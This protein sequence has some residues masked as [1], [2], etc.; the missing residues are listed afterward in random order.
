MAPPESFRVRGSFVRVLNGNRRLDTA[1]Q[2]ELVERVHQEIAPETVS[3][4]RQAAYDL[5]EVQ[6][7][8]QGHFLDSF[9][10]I[11]PGCTAVCGEQSICFGKS[12]I[13]T[14]VAKVKAYF[15]L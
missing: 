15:T 7:L 9:H 2:A 4:N 5:G 12:G 14:I 8:P 3:G 13:S 11:S 1:G 10:L 6:A